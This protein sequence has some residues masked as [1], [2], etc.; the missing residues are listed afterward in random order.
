MKE[1]AV[2]TPM[3]APIHTAAPSRAVPRPSGNP[4]RK[5]AEAW[6]P[7]RSLSHALV[8]ASLVIAGLYI[9]VFWRLGGVGYYTAEPSARGYTKWHRMLRPSG[10]VGELFGVAGFAVMLLTLFYV[11]R[12]KLGPRTKLG[13]MKSWLEF[14]I[15]CGLVGPALITLHTSFK[16]NGLISVAYWSMVLVVLS[17]FVGRY[18]FVRIP[19]TIRGTELSLTEIQER[20]AE[21]R[22]ELAAVGLSADLLRKVHAF[23][24]EEV[25]H[26]LRWRRLRRD[27]R[28]A[29]VS[30]TLLDETIRLVRERVA[31]ERRIANLA[32]T[33]KLFELWHVF[34]KPLVYVMLAIAAVHIGLAIYFG[35]SFPRR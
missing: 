34:H 7:M 13:S 6:F 5:P 23:E 3:T 25:G 26:R 15:F 11:M 31:L 12:K 19:K 18:L 2:R 28:R 17:G 14:H 22:E 21:L 10:S 16:F 29:R 20:A 4:A 1:E 8:L 30:R 9:F 35:Y 27:L 32:R 33:K 24:E